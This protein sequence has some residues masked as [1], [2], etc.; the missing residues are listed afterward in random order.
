MP[1][2]AGKA[3]KAG[4]AILILSVAAIV[5][6]VLLLASAPRTGSLDLLAALVFRGLVLTF[7]ATVAV[8]WLLPAP[9]P[10]RSRASAARAPPAAR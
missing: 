2:K 4:K 6:A 10:G 8:E 1:R 9:R 7:V 5:V 3:G